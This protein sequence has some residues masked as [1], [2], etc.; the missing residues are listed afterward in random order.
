VTG[1]ESSIPSAWNVNGG[2]AALTVPLGSGEVV[3]IAT[4]SPASIVNVTGAELPAALL[5]AIVKE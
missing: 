3:T 2:Y 5:A 4:F 1:Y